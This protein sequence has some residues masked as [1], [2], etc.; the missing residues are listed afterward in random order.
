MVNVKPD[1]GDSREAWASRPS[2]VPRG[3]RL[4]RKAFGTISP[5]IPLAALVGYSLWGARRLS[6]CPALGTGQVGDKPSSQRAL[7]SLLLDWSPWAAVTVPALQ[8]F[9]EEENPG[10]SPE[11]PLHFRQGRS[12]VAA[13]RDVQAQPCRNP[14]WHQRRERSQLPPAP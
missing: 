3:W 9:R 2:Q 7:E 12:W 8:G 1:K 6:C 5:S 14:W 11:H 4:P 10:W 13:L